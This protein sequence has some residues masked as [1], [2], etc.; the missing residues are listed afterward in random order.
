MDDILAEYPDYEAKLGGVGYPPGG[1]TL[2]GPCSQAGLLF[3]LVLVVRRQIS[4]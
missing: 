1:P 4:E 3:K 2:E